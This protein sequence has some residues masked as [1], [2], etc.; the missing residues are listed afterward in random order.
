[1]SS[2]HGPR[3]IQVLDEAW[4][5]LGS[6]RTSKYLQACW[7][8][9]RAYGVA[10][11]AIMHRLSDLK[12]QSDDGTSASKVAMGLLADTQTRII[13]RQSPDQI[14][15]AQELLGLTSSEADLLTQLTRGRALWKVAGRAAVVQHVVARGERGFCDTDA[16]MNNDSSA[17]GAIDAAV[18][19]AAAEGRA[20]VPSTLR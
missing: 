13:F 5:L 10:N 17:P 18:E 15:D 4:A 8:L 9:S 19:K 16:R 1:M 2:P 14:D 7:K 11:I 3:R 12:A 20:I 6:E